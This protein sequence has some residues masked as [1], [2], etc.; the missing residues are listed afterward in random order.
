MMMVSEFAP[1]ESVAGETAFFGVCL[2]DM[3]LCMNGIE[4]SD[5]EILS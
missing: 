3:S 1:A 5:H 2:R 4:S